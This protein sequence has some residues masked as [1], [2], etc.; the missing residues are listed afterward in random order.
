MADTQDITNEG[1]KPLSEDEQRK[2][3]SKIRLRYEKG[4][5][6]NELNRR[7]HTADMM[8]IYMADQQMQ[9]DPAVLALRA[10]RPSYTFNRVLQPVNMIL[11]D[12]RQTRPA[13]KVRPASQNATVD[14]ADIYGGLW[15][16]IE[17]ESRAETIY[18]ETY[19]GSV[20]GG[21]GE[22]RL[23]PEYESDQSFDQVLR[24]VG[25]PNPLT[26]VR[27]PESTDPCGADAM[28]CMVGD[29]I[30][31][32]KY[33]ELYPGD[34]P[35]TFAMARDSFGWRTDDMIR[36]VDYFERIAIVKEIAELTDG[37]VIKYTDEEKAVE[38]DLAKKGKNAPKG[39]ARV[40]RIRKVK[41]WKVLW[42]KCDGAR[43][44]EGPIEYDWQR[45]PVVR[46]P[47]RTANI[48]GRQLFQSYIRHS[49][50]SQ[51]SYNFQRSDAIERS[52]LGVKAPIMYTPKMVNGFDDQWA[53]AHVTPKVGL[54]FNVD[55][56][57]ATTPG[58]GAPYRIQPIDP[59]AA[60]TAMAELAA[61]DIQATTG[62]FDPALG[63][64]D[65]M[66]RVSGKA[67]V[68]HTRRSDLGSHEFIDNYG[69]A[70]QLLCEMG[71][72]MIPTIYDSAR[73]VRTIGAEGAE[74]LVK[75][76]HDAG[77]GNIVNDLK[78]GRYDCVVTLGPSYQTARQET[79]ATLIDAAQTI[80]AFAQVV[81]D[82]IARTIDSPD[83]EEMAKRLRALLVKQGI[84]QPTPQEKAQ[85]GPGP[86]PSPMDQAELTRAQALAA[87]DLANAHIA[88]GKAQAGD[89]E[90]HRVVLDTAAKHLA[91]LVMAQRLGQPNAAAQAEAQAGA[92]APPAPSAAPV[93]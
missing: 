12:Q 29:R 51:R 66:N 60:S 93:Q 39:A 15:R 32:E 70:I 3:L 56:D 8:F 83:S 87:R 85:M 44:L 27:D 74:K 47:G 38:K 5:G 59:P 77:G 16:S 54:P 76:N 89:L 24:L 43:V 22:L 9:W 91:N 49:W 36:V 62:A 4:V 81:P 31:K 84:V 19:K 41:A 48:E 42:L 13:V 30:S 20:G 35:T 21:F 75:V 2:L 53:N 25:I 82:L 63:N 10:G 40:K 17:V 86:Q 18:D 90:V 68:T 23:L 34:D 37:R 28:W 64:A 92:L 71:L 78:K 72:D 26:V 45:I 79:L 11:G 58:G 46:M 65:D 7:N 73:I 55:K 50:D 1:V 6:A 88:A 67:L 61:Q 57:A 80:P 33:D 69:K 52:A 14:I